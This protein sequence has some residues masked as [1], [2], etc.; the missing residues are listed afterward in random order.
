MIIASA[1]ML[2]VPSASGDVCAFGGDPARLVFVGGVNYLSTLLGVVFRIALSGKRHSM[3]IWLVI[4]LVTT[5]F[6]WV[7]VRKTTSR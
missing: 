1:V 2:I 3:C 5:G 7:S 4:V 6:Y